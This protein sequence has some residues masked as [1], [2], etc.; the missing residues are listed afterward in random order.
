MEKLADIEHDLKR[1]RDEI[2]QSRNL[3]K[4]TKEAADNGIQ[5]LLLQNTAQEKQMKRNENITAALQLKID[6]L[7]GDG[8]SSSASEDDQTK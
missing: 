3:I 7:L 5:V 4:S 6:E 8:A 2:M 1:A